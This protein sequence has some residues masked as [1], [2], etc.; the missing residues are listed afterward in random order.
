MSCKIFIN[1]DNF[2]WALL[3]LNF[4]GTAIGP[5]G[6][7]PSPFWPVE[8]L[9]KHKIAN[10]QTPPLRSCQAVVWEALTAFGTTCMWKFGRPGGCGC[11]AALPIWASL[12]CPEWAEGWPG[13]GVG[14]IRQFGSGLI[15]SLAWG[16]CNQSQLVFRVETVSAL[17]LWIRA[18]SLCLFR[19]KMCL[20]P[21][22]PDL[23]HYHPQLPVKLVAVIQKSGHAISE[24]Y[25]GFPLICRIFQGSLCTEPWFPQ[26]DMGEHWK[27]SFL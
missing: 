11:S 26:K 14:Q 24:W 19:C 18:R 25:F 15:S 10:F 12:R 8:D 16:G 5:L 6:K 7:P 1:E 2:K 27:M 20:Q 21:P 9:E 3:A 4:V 22:C 23:S 17:S 13:G